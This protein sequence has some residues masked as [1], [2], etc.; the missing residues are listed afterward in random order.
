MKQSSSERQ[1]KAKIEQTSF[2]VRS[3]HSRPGMTVTTQD[4]AFSALSISALS[5]VSIFSGVSG[6][7]I[8]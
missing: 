2:R 6:P 5:T 7:T 8:L 1:I 4:P 3:F